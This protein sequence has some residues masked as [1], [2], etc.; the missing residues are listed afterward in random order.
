MSPDGCSR[1]STGG[2]RTPKLKPKN[3]RRPTP[4][5][6]YYAGYDPGFVGDVLTHLSLDKES[7]VLDPWN[8]SGTTTAVVALS[9]RS[10]VGLDINPVL[11][12]VAKSK[13]LTTDVAESLEALTTQ[14]LACAK[15]MV[16]VRAADDPLT[17]WFTAGTAAY[18]RAIERS[19]Q[20]LLVEKN[21]ALRFTNDAALSRLSALASSFYVVLFEAVRGLL[22]SYMTTN[23]T[24]VKLSSESSGPVSTAKEKIDARFRAAERRQHKHL[25]QLRLRPD[26]APLDQRLRVS[27]ASSTATGLDSSSVDACVGS[28]PYCTRID[29]PVLTRPELAVLG[30]GD[31]S[32]MRALRDRSIGTTTMTGDA[33]EAQEAW[34]R[35]INDFLTAVAAHSSKASKTYYRRYFL[36]YF[37][38][39]HKSLLE[40]RR[41]L[42]D[43]APCA[44]VV[45]DSYYK[46]LRNDLA[47]GLIEMGRCVG[48]ERAERFDF[49]VPRTRAAMHAGARQY[50]DSFTATE[51]LIVLRS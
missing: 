20:N 31:D 35:T 48:W 50:R 36:Q 41:V 17:Q 51:S 2:I 30:I 39:M 27:L 12:V 25:Q 40:L 32:E 16:V 1:P 19:V 13:L 46:E 45:Q 37:D 34:G 8:G 22:R 7:V 6:Q 9:G 21:G 10:A 3:G 49:V 42:K 26:G 44:L 38:E 23:P 11:V 28:P 43:D 47:T 4:G 33:P 15:E 14:I 5:S 29:Y 24:W 18:L